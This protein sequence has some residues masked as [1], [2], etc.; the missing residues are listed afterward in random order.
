[1]DMNDIESFEVLKDAASAAI[2]GARGGNG[3]IHNYY[4][5]RKRRKNS[6]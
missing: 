3:V 4:K 1:M 6:I 5:T 2:F